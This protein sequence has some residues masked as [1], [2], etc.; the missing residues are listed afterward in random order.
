MHFAACGFLLGGIED[1]KKKKKNEKNYLFPNLKSI[2][3]KVL[4]QLKK[5]LWSV[6]G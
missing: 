2:K 3:T 5:N 4:K 6:I 1:K